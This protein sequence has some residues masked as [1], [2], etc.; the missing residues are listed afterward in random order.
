MNLNETLQN[1]GTNEKASNESI[2]KLHTRTIRFRLDKLQKEV[3]M[4]IE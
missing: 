2:T 4:I 3:D 1:L